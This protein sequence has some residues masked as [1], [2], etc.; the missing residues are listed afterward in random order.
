MPMKIFKKGALS[1]ANIHDWLIALRAHSYIPFSGYSATAI[2][3]ARAGAEDDYYFAGTN[4]ENIDHRLT[5][6]AEE[7]AISAMV[8]ALGRSAE[9]VE[10]WVMGAPLEEAD[11]NNGAVTAR[12]NGLGS[13]CGKC[14]QQIAGFAADNVKIHSIGLDGARA[15][16]TVGTFLPRPFTFR[17]YRTD[18]DS[19]KSTQSPSATKINQHL[20]RKGD[21]STD[22]ILSWLQ[23]LDSVDYVTQTTQSV[24]LR[25]SNGVTVAGVG[26][27]EAAFISINAMQ[28]AVSTA[29][30]LYGDVRITEVWSWAKGRG[31][32]EIP[33]GSYMALMPSALQTLLPFAKN[34][35][36]PIHF[37]FAKGKPVTSELQ[38][39]IETAL[40]EGLTA[41]HSR[42]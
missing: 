18:I 21:L 5:T 17:K 14:R 7:G 35:H 28:S 4:V 24:A 27:E 6:H 32:H 33:V 39:T 13:C 26:I 38:E 20:M 41:L 36:I 31:D 19:K 12:G 3:R 37:L 15:S 8:T 23:E 10:G 16:T 22:D 1:Q 29:V 25:L 9:I 42:T 30:G 34:A 40:E 2:F 11:A